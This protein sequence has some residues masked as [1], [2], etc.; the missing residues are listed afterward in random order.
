M[1]SSTR[2]S[3]PPGTIFCTIASTI[4]W[5]LDSSI[6]VQL[7]ATVAPSARSSATPLATPRSVGDAHGRLEHD[8]I[9]ELLGRC[10]GTG[11]EPTPVAG[12]NRTP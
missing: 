5:P 9:P 3:T 2:T 12:A 4:G 8:G 11:Q 6:C 1:C 7:V 10:A